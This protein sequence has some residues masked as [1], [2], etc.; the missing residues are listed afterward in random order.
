[1]LG[2]YTV[3]DNRSRDTLILI[4]INIVYTLNDLSEYIP[5]KKC[6]Y[7]PLVLEY[8]QI[9]GLLIMKQ[10]LKMKIIFFIE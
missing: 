7:S 6:I 2:I 3:L 10:N 5:E 8:I 9:V 4:V 1:M